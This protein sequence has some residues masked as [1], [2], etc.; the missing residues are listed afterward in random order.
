MV[1]VSGNATRKASRYGHEE[2]DQN[3]FDYHKHIKVNNIFKKYIIQPELEPGPEL[4]TLE[5]WISRSMLD[6]LF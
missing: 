1:F 3:N 4:K 2:E 5:Y 6:L